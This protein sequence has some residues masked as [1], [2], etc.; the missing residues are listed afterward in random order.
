MKLIS[1][2]FGFAALATFAAAVQQ[3]NIRIDIPRPAEVAQN[4][5][6]PIRGIALN[7]IAQYVKVQEP[8]GMIPRHDA[9]ESRDA[10]DERKPTRH[11]GCTVTLNSKTKAREQPVFKT[12]D[13]MA[14]CC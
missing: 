14:V 6:S 10:L 3:H 4:P 8:C 9:A 12:E 1:T 11:S 2:L 7:A 13:D 5:C